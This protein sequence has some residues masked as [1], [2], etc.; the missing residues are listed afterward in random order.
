MSTLA[1]SDLFFFFF[2]FF[3]YFF[4]EKLSVHSQTWKQHQSW[5]LHHAEEQDSHRP[6]TLQSLLQK[7]SITFCSL[8]PQR[9]IC[10][11]KCC[12]IDE[13]GSFKR[14]NCNVR[15][16]D[17]VNKQVWERLFSNERDVVSNSSLFTCLADFTK[18]NNFNV[19]NC[20]F[21]KIEDFAIFGMLLRVWWCRHSRQL[22]CW[23]WFNLSSPVKFYFQLLVLSFGQFQVN[24]KVLKWHHHIKRFIAKE[25]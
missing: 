21:S 10:H 1:F 5:A 19:F 6:V 23:S 8:A 12:A 24:M 18:C 22:F 7:P 4:F 9:W 2:F 25:A 20:L 15:L 17:I 3:I 11:S 16:C 14:P 13:C